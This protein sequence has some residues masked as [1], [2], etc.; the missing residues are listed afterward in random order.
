MFVTV[1]FFNY[2]LTILPCY[3]PGIIAYTD[4][5]RSSSLSLFVLPDLFGLTC[6]GIIETKCHSNAA[7][8]VF[9]WHSCFLEISTFR[10]DFPS[11]KMNAS[12]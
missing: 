10:F 11:R 3:R 4:E 1:T 12:F 9:E 6:K 7:Q 8:K 5:F 2:Y